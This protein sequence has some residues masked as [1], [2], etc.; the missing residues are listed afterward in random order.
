MTEIGIEMIVAPLSA[1]PAGEGRC[2]DVAGE[3]I[4][5]FNTRQGGVFAVQANCPHKG[6]PLSDGLVGGS[7]II[8]PLHS[9]KFDLT[10]GAA[11]MGDCGLKTFPA[12][13][14]EQGR[15][16]VKVAENG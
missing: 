9:W 10:T 2:F 12:R 13:L 6:A 7:T 3:R 14:D 16:L 1:I 8:C 4:A 11:Q 5:I 15:V